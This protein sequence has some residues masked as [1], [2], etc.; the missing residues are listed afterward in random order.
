M[1]AT[2]MQHRVSETAARVPGA[3]VI[4]RYA[5]YAFSLAGIYLSVGFLFYYAAKEKLIDDGGTMPAGLVKAFNGSFFASVPGDNAS[6]VLLGIMEAAIVVLLAISL[7]TGEFLP[8]R[9]KP[10]LLAALGFATLTLAV[11]IIANSMTGN[12]DLV[13]GQFTYLGVAVI[14]TFVV[15]QLPPYRPVTWIA[16]EAAEEQ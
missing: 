13:L 16:G 8:H 10:V 15:R 2:T 9:R 11:M 12:T 5:T 7:V 6:W 14:L 4:A 3:N 1:S